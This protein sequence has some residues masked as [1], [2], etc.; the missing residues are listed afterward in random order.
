MVTPERAFSPFNKR[1]QAEFLIADITDATL[2]LR[3]TPA[4][5]RLTMR[6][7]FH[8]PETSINA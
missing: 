3:N 1:L 8:P 4:P 2:D 7:V 5:F 6:R